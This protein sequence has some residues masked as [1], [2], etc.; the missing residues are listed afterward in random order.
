MMTVTDA[1]LELPRRL[2]R[3]WRATLRSGASSA[4]R[5]ILRDFR[6]GRRPRE[7]F[8]HVHHVRLARLYLL[9]APPDVAVPR[10]CR[11]LRRFATAL[12][13]P[14]QYHETISR[15]FLLLV[16]ERIARCGP[17]RSFEEFAAQHP[18]L[19]EW[20][21][22]ILS[23]Y[24]RPETLASDFARRSFVLPD[25]GLW[26]TRSIDRRPARGVASK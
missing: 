20:K 2:A 22:S 9:Q 19:L 18:E 21:P 25:A 11:D 10:Y 3:L 23:R 6:A 14:G 1:L 26:A 16:A 8:H 12:G 24:Y 13:A 5:L 17:G 15:A 7:G 4:D